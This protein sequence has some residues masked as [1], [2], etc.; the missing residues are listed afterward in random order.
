VAVVG[1]TLLCAVSLSANNTNT[2]LTD[3]ALAS[4]G[5]PSALD[6]EG[7]ALGANLNLQQDLGQA[8]DLEQE[9]NRCHRSRNCRSRKCRRAQQLKC[10]TLSRMNSWLCPR[11]MHPRRRHQCRKMMWRYLQ[12]KIHWS[13]SWGGV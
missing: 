11:A 7:A 2:N 5:D 8:L 9:W 3:T 1:L 4:E 12:G 10:A 13:R 6:Q